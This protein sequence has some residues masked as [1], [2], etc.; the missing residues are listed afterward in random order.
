VII[1]S[2]QQIIELRVLARKGPDERALGDDLQALRPN[3]LERAPHQGGSHPAAAELRRNLGVDERDH[4]RRHAAM[5]K[6]RVAVD[7]ELE[8]M[9]DSHISQWLYV[10]Q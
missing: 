4:S 7:L 2:R 6:R 9:L 10:N 1:G 3:E 8:P 5:G